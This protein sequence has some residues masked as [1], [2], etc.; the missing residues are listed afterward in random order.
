MKP[1]PSFASTGLATTLP[2]ATLRTATL[3]AATVMAAMLSL[4]AFG[5]TARTL[6]GTGRPDGTVMEMQ[7]ER[8][9]PGIPAVPRQNRSAAEADT[10]APADRVPA[11]WIRQAQ[12]QL[13]ANR[14]GL[15]NELLER[16]ETRLLSRVSLATEAGIPLA[17]DAVRHLAAARAALLAN[18]LET[19][20]SA[21]AMALAAVGGAP[22]ADDISG[23]APMMKRGRPISP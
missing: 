22:M 13:R 2:A 23:E 14:Y 16:A 8:R 3:L 19:A 12:H 9:T 15:A 17:S 11:Q 4:P 6:H 18:D 5:Q 1:T 20:R 10:V 7:Q 21:T